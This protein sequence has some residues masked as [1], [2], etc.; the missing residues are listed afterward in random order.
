MTESKAK[1]N[2]KNIVKEINEIF[3]LNYIIFL[4]IKGFA[5]DIYLQ[6]LN[7][8][9]LLQILVATTCNTLCIERGYFFLRMVFAQVQ[10]FKTRSLGGSFLLAVLKLPVKK[11]KDCDVE[12]KLIKKWHLNSFNISVFHYTLLVSNKNIFT[13][14]VTFVDISLQLCH[15]A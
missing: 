10:S 6:C 12:V 3:W 5:A 15:H 7:V 8:C 1:E 9:K 4:F 14:V 2:S 13:H 11:S